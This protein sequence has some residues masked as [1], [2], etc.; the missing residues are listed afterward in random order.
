MKSTQGS[1]VETRIEFYDASDFAEVSAFWTQINRQL[2]PD[3]MRDAFE[4]YIDSSINNELANAESTFP[5][6]NGSA[7]WVVVSAEKIIGTF[8]IQRVNTTDAELRRMYLASEY[9]GQALSRKMLAHAETYASQQGFERMILSTAELQAAAV[10]FYEK[11]GYQL[12]KTELAE[13][14][15]NKTVGGNIRRR[16]YAKQLRQAG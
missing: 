3:N 9:R 8:G 4:R 15:S 1:N 6:D 11:S 16:H 13:T 14:S 12:T 2:A 5:R 10:K 7:L